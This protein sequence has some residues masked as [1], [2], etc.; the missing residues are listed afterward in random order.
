[1]ALLPSY[2]ALPF[3]PNITA[4]PVMMETCSP[5]YEAQKNRAW[6]AWLKTSCS[7]YKTKIWCDE[8]LCVEKQWRLGGGTFNFHSGLALDLC[9]Q[10]LK[11]SDTRWSFKGRLFVLWSLLSNK[12]NKHPH[13]KVTTFFFVWLTLPLWSA[14]K[15]HHS[16]SE[17]MFYSSNHWT[18]W[19]W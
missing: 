12:Q 18:C 14:N 5:H 6:E 1:M 15:S 11:V 8:C 2:F 9:W 13:S 17:A 16:E 7:Y 10:I 19:L 3:A 4:A